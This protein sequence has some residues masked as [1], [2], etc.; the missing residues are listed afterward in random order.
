MEEK[1]LDKIREELINSMD[2]N[3]AEDIIMDNKKE[4][5]YKGIKYRVRIPLFKEKQEIYKKRA[6]K[7]LELLESKGDNG[8][9]LYKKE[10]D[11]RKIHRDRGNS[12]EK[13]EEDFNVLESQR[14]IYQEKL[15]E[16]LKNKLPDNELKIFYDQINKI[17]KEQEELIKQKT[18]LLEYSLDNQ[19][20]LFI[21]AEA[22]FLLTDKFENNNWVRVWNKFSEYEESDPILITLATYYTTLLMNIG[23]L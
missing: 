3:L 22:T 7:Y 2:K 14:N 9:Y 12:I 6:E 5:D 23:S 18:S 15:G 20:L 16:A 4:F 8:K 13:I 17:K 1:S 19:L 11:L 10:E 21:Y